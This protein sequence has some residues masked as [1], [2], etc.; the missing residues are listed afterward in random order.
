MND[1]S[2]IFASLQDGTSVLVALYDGEDRLRYANP[3][4]RAAYHLD[5]AET[6]LWP[7]LMRRNHRARCGTVIRAPDFEAWLTS[8]QSRRG[9]T[10]F[11]A[12]ETDLVDGRWL[13]MTEAVQQDGWM[14]CIASDITSLRAEERIVR[15]ARDLAIR[16]SQTD[17]LTGV[18]NRRFVMERLEHMLQG[19]EPSPGPHGSIALLD[20]DRFKRINDDHGHQ[21]GDQVLCDFAARM[22]AQ[23]RRAD[24]FGRVGGEEFLLVLPNTRIEQAR[25]IVERMLADLC[26]SPAAPSLPGLVYTFS[27][28]LAEARPG[29]TASQLYAR[30]DRALYTAKAGGRSRIH[31]DG[32]ALARTAAA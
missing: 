26:G 23:V 2:S 19:P 8:T 22:Q 11:R 32:P 20:I 29:D 28:G 15:Q 7:D 18:S 30:A 10:G 17:D 24:C 1:V 27:A 25:A 16:A 13:W 31:V 5:A 4:F 3:A 9:K 6:P 21:A 14:L 12:F